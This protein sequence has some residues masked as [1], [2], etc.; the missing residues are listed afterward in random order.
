MTASV[1]SADERASEPIAVVGIGCRFPG[2]VEDP[3]GLWDV[4]SDGR[5]VVTEFPTDRGWDIEGLFDPDPDAPG[6][7]YS[8]WGG[9]LIGTYVN[10]RGS[11]Y[12]LL[13]TIFSA[14]HEG[15]LSLATL[16]DALGRPF[17]HQGP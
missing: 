3:D 11:Q 7:T 14:T 1:E 4:V 12:N 5:D 2:G 13:D 9:T 8:R 15:V 10:E 17:Q 6:K 16:R